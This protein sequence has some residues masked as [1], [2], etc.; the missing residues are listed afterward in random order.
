MYRELEPRLC[1]GTGMLE[2]YTKGEET[3]NDHW[4]RSLFLG[5]IP[6]GDILFWHGVCYTL[7]ALVRGE[8]RSVMDWRL[9]K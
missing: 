1:Q 9:L 7:V 4:D 3:W 6:A 2:A 5:F 8:K